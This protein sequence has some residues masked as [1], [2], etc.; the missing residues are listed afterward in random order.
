[1]RVVLDPI[2]MLT[3]SFISELESFNLILECRYGTAKDLDKLYQIKRKLEATKDEGSYRPSPQ[4]PVA[5][6]TRN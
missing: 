4:A 2:G 1:M 3:Y 5:W 6:T